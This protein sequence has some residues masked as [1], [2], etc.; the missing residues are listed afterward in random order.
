M[1]KTHREKFNLSTRRRRNENDDDNDENR[2]CTH[3]NRPHD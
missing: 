2:R 1:K 3:P